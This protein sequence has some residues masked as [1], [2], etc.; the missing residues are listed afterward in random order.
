MWSSSPV[1]LNKADLLNSGGATGGGRH[2][3]MEG[4]ELQS[5]SEDDTCQSYRD[6]S[7]QTGYFLK[8]KFI[9]KAADN[10]EIIC[11]KCVDYLAQ[12]EFF[13]DEKQHFLAV[14]LNELTNT[15]F[16]LLAQF[17]E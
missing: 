5:E 14:L 10:Y 11:Q 3:L 17:F 6:N 9:L 7:Y 1:L 2:I 4:E 13:S 16:L 15:N 8:L 12:T